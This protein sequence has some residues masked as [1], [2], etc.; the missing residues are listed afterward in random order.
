[1]E[2]RENQIS[3]KALLLPTIMKGQSTCHLFKKKSDN[4]VKIS[5]RFSKKKREYFAASLA[6]IR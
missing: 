3:I 5:K 1:L 6:Y 4:T 2:Q